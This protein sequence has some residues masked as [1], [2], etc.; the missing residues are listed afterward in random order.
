[1]R[2]VEDW[3]AMAGYAGRPETVTVVLDWADPDARLTGRL[4]ELDTEGEALVD[5]GTGRRRG[6]PALALL[7]GQ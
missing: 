4:L 1:V 2:I 6:W 5:T 3:P 7:V